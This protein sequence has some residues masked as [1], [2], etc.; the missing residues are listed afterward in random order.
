MLSGETR[1]G[2]TDPPSGVARQII[3]GRERKRVRSEDSGAADA[4]RQK[5]CCKAK[6]AFEAGSN[7]KHRTGRENLSGRGKIWGERRA[8][9]RSLGLRSDFP[10]EMPASSNA[11]FRRLPAGGSIAAIPVIIVVVVTQT[12]AVRIE[13]VQNHP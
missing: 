9:R 11:H 13:V 1:C 7:S 12:F 10:S 2:G 4:S 8:G 5:I 6:S 3:C